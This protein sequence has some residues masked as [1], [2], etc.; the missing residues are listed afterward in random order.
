LL[1]VV[2][3]S[4]GRAKVVRKNRELIKRLKLLQRAHG[5]ESV[6]AFADHLGI[7]R[8][9]LHNITQGVPLSFRVADIMVKRTPGLDLDWL[10]YGVTDGLSKALADRLELLGRRERD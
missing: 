10:Y 1:T 8:Q 9:R 2:G 3:G 6:A 4:D 7:S 5:F